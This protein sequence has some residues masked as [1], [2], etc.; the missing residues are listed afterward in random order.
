MQKKYSGFQHSR[1]HSNHRLQWLP[2]LCKQLHKTLPLHNH[3]M[4]RGN[5]IS[6]VYLYFLLRNFHISYQLLSMILLSG[7][8]DPVWTSQMFLLAFSV[9]ESQPLVIIDRGTLPICNSLHEVCECE[10]H[11][12]FKLVEQPWKIITDSSLWFSTK[13]KNSHFCLYF[14]SSDLHKWSHNGYFT[15]RPGPGLLGKPSFWLVSNESS[16]RN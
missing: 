1:N 8:H 7:I 14:T 9:H 5:T 2:N 12:R 4:D 6:L 16:V 13:P 10:S 3:V 11:S 15:R